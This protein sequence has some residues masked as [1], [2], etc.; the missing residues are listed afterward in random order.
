M[1]HTGP[2]GD[3]VMGVL[4]TGP[5]LQRVFA[6]SRK[7]MGRHVFPTCPFPDRALQESSPTGVY[8]KLSQE[9]LETF[10]SRPASPE[11]RSGK[12]NIS[13]LHLKTGNIRFKIRMLIIRHGACLFF[14]GPPPRGGGGAFRFL[15]WVGDFLAPSVCFVPGAQPLTA[16]RDAPQ[17]QAVFRTWPQGSCPAWAGGHPEQEAE[18]APLGTQAFLGDGDS[19]SSNLT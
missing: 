7:W 16:H 5:L 1:A 15:P 10:L 2:L 17:R 8:W 9:S 14:H 6:E 3:L 12:R 11:V 19:S 13:R 18:L 4:V